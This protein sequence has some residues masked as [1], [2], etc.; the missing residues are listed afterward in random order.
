[1]LFCRVQGSSSLSARESC[2]GDLDVLRRVITK[3]DM[4]FFFNSKLQCSTS[5]PSRKTHIHTHSVIMLHC[6]FYT[7]PPCS[8]VTLP[9]GPYLNKLSQHLY[10]NLDRNTDLFNLAG[11][12]VVQWSAPSTHSKLFRAWGGQHPDLFRG[13]LVFSMCPIVQ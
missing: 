3:T 4:L 9:P 12:T 6:F 2:A 10:N 5:K 13:L 1:M 11:S 8:S 7:L